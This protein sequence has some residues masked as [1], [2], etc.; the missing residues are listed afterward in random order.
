MLSQNAATLFKEIQNSLALREKRDAIANLDR[1][2]ELAR[3]KGY[4]YTQQE[5]RQEIENLSEEEL[6][7]LI[8]PGVSPRHH[9]LAR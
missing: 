6:A 5:L 3:Q 1:F 4:R 8:N 9:I 2:M 7:T